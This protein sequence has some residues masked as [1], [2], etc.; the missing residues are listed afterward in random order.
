MSLDFLPKEVEAIIF[1]YKEELDTW[2]QHCCELNKVMTERENTLEYRFTRNSDLRE[3]WISRE[4]PNGNYMLSLLVEQLCSDQTI[5]CEF[6]VT[7]AFFADDKD[8]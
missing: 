6:L 7:D 8:L 3:F 1:D 5:R 4:Y 2:D